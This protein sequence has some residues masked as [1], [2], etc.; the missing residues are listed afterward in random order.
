[1]LFSPENSAHPIL[2]WRAPTAGIAEMQF[3]IRARADSPEGDVELFIFAVTA[4]GPEEL[5]TLY[6]SR[7]GDPDANGRATVPSPADATMSMSAS[8]RLEAGDGMYIYARVGDDD[9]FDIAIL[10][11]GVRFTPAR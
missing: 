8:T 7:D 10:R 5:E 6:I 9:A 2:E 1:M 11:G 4:A 3:E